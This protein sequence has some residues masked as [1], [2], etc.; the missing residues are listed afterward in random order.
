MNH[1]SINADRS[2]ARVFAQASCRGKMHEADVQTEFNQL[3][4]A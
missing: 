4:L 1:G 2:A 3:R